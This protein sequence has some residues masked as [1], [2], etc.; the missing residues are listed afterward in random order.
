[1]QN[2]TCLLSGVG[3]LELLIRNSQV[4]AADPDSA[5]RGIAAVIGQQFF[6]MIPDINRN[7]T[8]VSSVKHCDST[9]LGCIAES[10]GVYTYKPEE[11]AMTYNGPAQWN[12]TNGEDIDGTSTSSYALF[13][14]VATLGN[15]TIYGLPF[16]TVDNSS[17][18]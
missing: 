12:G 18:K 17:G 5:V 3:P 16:A 7:D 13:N 6:S 4:I 8:L 10:G 11:G 15:A 1:M 2:S 14:D 9:S